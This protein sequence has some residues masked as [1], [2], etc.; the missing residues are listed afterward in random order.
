MEIRQVCLDRVLSSITPDWSDYT[1]DLYIFLQLWIVNKAEVPTTVKAWRL[2][3]SGDGG[4]Q[5]IPTEQ[6][7]DISKWHQHTKVKEEQHGLHV[8]KDVRE[9]LVAFPLEP[10]RQ[11]IAIEG[12]VCFKAEGV[13]EA[14]LKTA[15]LRLEIVDSFGRRHAVKTLSP[16]NCKGDVVNPKMPW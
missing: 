15:K 8:I 16:W 5:E 4:R 1:F 13:R 3:L 11:G 6:F 9:D 10:L 7:P 2:T 14:L 12:W